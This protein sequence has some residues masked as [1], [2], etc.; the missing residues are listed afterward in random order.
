[1]GRFRRSQDWLLQEEEKSGSK[2][3]YWTPALW[4]AVVWMDLL[5]LFFASF[6][7]N[8]NSHLKAE[9]SKAQE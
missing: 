8:S 5:P 9:Q 4:C 3:V 7:Y 2:E 6:F 1:M